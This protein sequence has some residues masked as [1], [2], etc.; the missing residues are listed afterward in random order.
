ENIE[1]KT[2]TD[3]NDIKILTSQMNYILVGTIE[4][5]EVFKKFFTKK[6]VKIIYRSRGVAPEESLYRN[7]SKL[8]FFVLSIIEYLVA[9]LSS[10]II[11]VSNEHKKHYINKYKINM[12]KISTIHNYLTKESYQ[13]KKNIDSKMEIVYSGGL[14]KWQKID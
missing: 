12:N 11:V 9:K 14:S 6:N 13:F 1:I 8:R 5:Y 10:H 4:F 2:V 7:N 3:I